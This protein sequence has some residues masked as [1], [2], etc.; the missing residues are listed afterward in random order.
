[1][2]LPESINGVDKRFRF[3]VEWKPQD[4]WVGAFWKTTRYLSGQKET[5]L[6]VCILPMIPLHFHW[7]RA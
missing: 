5:H 2:N 6:W 1:V 3:R 4:A 7:W